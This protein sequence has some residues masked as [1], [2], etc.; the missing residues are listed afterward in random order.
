MRDIAAEICCAA[1]DFAATRFAA[2]ATTARLFLRLGSS[3][4]CR[5]ACAMLHAAD[6][7]RFAPRR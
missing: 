7:A 2:A 6:S 1:A 4:Y 3:P 5:A